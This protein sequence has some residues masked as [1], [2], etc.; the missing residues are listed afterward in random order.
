MENKKFERIKTMYTKKLILD[1]CCGG[2]LFW[3]NKNHPNTVYVDQ[4]Q[5]KYLFSENRKIKVKPDIVANFKE[6]PYPDNTFKLVIF[7]PPHTTKAGKNSWLVKKY[8]VLPLDWKDE[9]F[10]GF[11]E[12]WRVLCE[13]GVLIFK[14][15]EVNI[16]VEEILTV[17]KKQ[18]LFGHK[19]GKASNTHWLCF[20]KI[21][22][23]F[24]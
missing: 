15:N 6:L 7:D 12:C 2:K 18:P 3:F 22:H 23:N 5:G 20:M 19:S 10:K 14:W 13:N 4:R 24:I 8:G 11:N 9:I 21:K 16:T 17:I 1:V